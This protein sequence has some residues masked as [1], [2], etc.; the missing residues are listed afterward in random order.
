MVSMRELMEPMEPMELVACSGYSGYMTS[1]DECGMN[2]AWE[3]GGGT[4]RWEVG[5]DAAIPKGRTGSGGGG[6]EEEAAKE[7]HSRDRSPFFFFFV[8]YSTVV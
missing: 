1:P 7:E 4:R 6:P 5:G 2:G 8:Q 3:G